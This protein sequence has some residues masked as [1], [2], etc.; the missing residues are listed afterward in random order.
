MRSGT[1]SVWQEILRRIEMDQPAVFVY[2]P[3]FAYAVN[4]R[5]DKAPIRPESS[6]LLVREWTYK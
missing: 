5:F 1:A 2:A 3:A 6:W 4:R